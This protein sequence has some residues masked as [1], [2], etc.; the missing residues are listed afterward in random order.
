MKIKNIKL[1]ELE[2]EEQYL[3]SYPIKPELH[4]QIKMKFTDFPFI[5]INRNN[6]IIFGIDSFFY[7]KE[8]N[9]T[10]LDVFQTDLNEKDA[11]ILN[12][13]LK[14][15]LFG[16]N[17]YEKLIFIKKIFS[18][19]ESKEIYKRTSLDININQELIEKLDVILSNEFKDILIKNGVNLKAAL[20]L[21]NLEKN[22]RKYLLYLFMRVPFSNS[23]QLQIIEM[24][25]E[26]LFREKTSIKE[27]LSKLDLKKYYN[28]EKPQKRILDDIFRYRYP[29]Y[30]K[31]RENWKRNIKKLKLPSNIKIS[32]HPFFEKKQTELKVSFQN[33]DKIKK[34]IEKLKSINNDLFNGK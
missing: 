7:F 16:L 24:T 10:D 28:L 1:S 21:C 2:F 13:N 12:Y 14:D 5:I 19:A 15:K 34:F 22:N 30:S 31:N 17:Q 33:P 29:L 27:I 4:N 26:I 20:K 9:L 18:Y 3:L 23:H 25:E 32:Y 11:L 6:S 8:K